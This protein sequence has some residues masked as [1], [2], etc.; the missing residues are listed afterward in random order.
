MIY[1]YDLLIYLSIFQID[2]VVGLQVHHL[3]KKINSTATSSTGKSI[4]VVSIL[5]NT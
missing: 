3:A 1:S 4:E 5:L 2:V